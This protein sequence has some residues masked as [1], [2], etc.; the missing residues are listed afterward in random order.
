MTRH[1][2]LMAVL[3]HRPRDIRL[4]DLGVCLGAGSR[5]DGARLNWTASLSHHSMI[6]ADVLAV[7]KGVFGIL[8]GV[9]LCAA[10]V[11]PGLEAV[12][13]RNGRKHIGRDLENVVGADDGANIAEAGKGVPHERVDL[14]RVDKII[15]G[16]FGVAVCCV[17]L[18]QHAVAGG[19][20][21]HMSS[22]CLGMLVWDVVSEGH[23]RRLL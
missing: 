14:E 10:A 2:S 22:R 17:Q 8:V 20:V 3:V 6:I 12:R 21:G 18:P 19:G 13:G 15:N 9:G 4:V 16:L 11:Q 23:W 1:G 5:R 7:T